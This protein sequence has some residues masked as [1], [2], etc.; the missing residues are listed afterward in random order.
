M[1]DLHCHIL[2]DIDDGASSFDESVVM[3]KNAS[4]NKLDIVTA[5]PH[6]TDYDAIEDFVFERDERAELLNQMINEFNINVKVVCGAELYLSSRIFTAGDLDELTINGSKYMLCE[7]S[8]KRFDPE[9]AIIYAEELINRGYIPIIAHPERY[10]SFFEEPQIMNE[11]WDMGC[12]FQIN[13]SGLAGEGGENMQE[14]ASDMILRGF[15]DFIATD[16]HSPRTRNNKI[17]S[18]IDE[19]PEEISDEQIEYLTSTA[20]LKVIKN[21]KL[22][23]RTVEY[24]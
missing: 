15:V 19:F 10:I 3:I 1:I 7:Y 14:F 13:A 5:T 18:K 8:L 23:M 20:P 9:K 2:P 24:F 16:A 22:D 12:R 6:F 11:L 21:E 4:K 17:L